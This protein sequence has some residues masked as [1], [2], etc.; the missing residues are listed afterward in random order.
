VTANR[1]STPEPISPR[2]MPATKRIDCRSQVEA[3]DPRRTRPA[4]SGGPEAPALIGSAPKAA[5][6]PFS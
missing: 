5:I 4:D 6:G 3:T 2:E 1:R